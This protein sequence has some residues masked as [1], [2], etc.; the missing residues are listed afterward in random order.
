MHN[1]SKISVK[2]TFKS[3]RTDSSKMGDIDRYCPSLKKTEIDPAF[4]NP[5]AF[6]FRVTE[7]EIDFYPSLLVILIYKTCSFTLQK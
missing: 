2:C 6:P 1:C 4:K 3:L 7:H 5:G